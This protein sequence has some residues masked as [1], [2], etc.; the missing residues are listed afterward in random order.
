M[1]RVPRTYRLRE[2]YVRELD[3]QA[4]HRGVDK[5]KIIEEALELV[6]SPTVGIMAANGSSQGRRTDADSAAESSAG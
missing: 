4:A 6:L 5:T 1:K 2:D 3:R